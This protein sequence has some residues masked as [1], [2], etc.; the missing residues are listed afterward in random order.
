MTI[1]FTKSL[2][3]NRGFTLVE[4]LVVIAIIGILA[5]LLLLQLNQARAKGRDAK[6]VSDISQLRTSLELYYNDHG[7]SYP[8]ALSDAN[9]GPYLATGRVPLD[10]STGVGYFYAYAPAACV[11][12]CT[13]FHL[14]AELET[15]N[16][17]AFA[18]RARINSTGWSGDAL[19]ASVAGAAGPCTSAAAHDC[20]FDVGQNQ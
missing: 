11:T 8:T 2:R 12:T 20:T 18:T 4:L 15:N 10:P 13:M 17:S 5:T 3:G 16:S 6:R 7:Y 1:P 14:Y 19:D 9:L